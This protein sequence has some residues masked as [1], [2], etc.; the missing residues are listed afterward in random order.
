[1]DDGWFV[2]FEKD[3]LDFHRR[4]TGRSIFQVRFKTQ[5]GGY[6]IIEAWSS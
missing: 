2:F 3:W 6:Q 4:W 5:N 1:M